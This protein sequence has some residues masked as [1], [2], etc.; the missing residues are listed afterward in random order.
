[1]TLRILA[2]DNPVAFQLGHGPRADRIAARYE[3]MD[4][5]PQNLAVAIG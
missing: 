3:G 5:I 1:M 4:H 2:D